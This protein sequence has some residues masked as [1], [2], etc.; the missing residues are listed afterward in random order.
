MS[1]LRAV[2]REL[3][4]GLLQLVYPAMCAA[5]NE[6]L[7]EEQ[8]AFCKR[9]RSAI[10]SDPYP[11][12]PRCASTVGPFI[13]PADGCAACRGESFSFDGV[14]RMGPYDGLLRDL[15]LRVKQ[16][17][18]ELLAELLA[19]L[20]AEHIEARVRSVNA[21]VVIPVPLHWWRKWLRGHNQSE[22]LARALAKRLRLPCPA[23]WLRRIR[24]TPRQVQQTATF[25]RENVRHAFAARPRLELKDKTVLLVDDVLTTGSTASEA[26]KALRSA[27]AARVT[28]AVLAHSQ[29]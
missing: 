18:G 11:S 21:Q 14:I 3:T 24:N 17:T 22:A 25:R 2:G 20:W 9:C 4:R 10:T 7:P 5:C 6:P 16:S 15:I 29:R 26:S 19:A 1:K 8:R 13:A 28:V 27:G 12:C 23:H